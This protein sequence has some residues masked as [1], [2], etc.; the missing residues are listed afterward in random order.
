MRT[1]ILLLATVFG[2]VAPAAAQSPQP[3]EGDRRDAFDTSGL[4]LTADQGTKLKGIL[5]QLQQQNAPFR[6]QLRQILGGKS[7]RDLTPAERD[8]WRPQIEPLR[9]QMMEN[10]RKAHDQIHAILTPA[11]RKTVEQR[12]RERRGGRGEGPPS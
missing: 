11:Q 12:M 2:L 9:R 5:K 3:S 1:T 8:S 10:R 7:F 6:E 4:G